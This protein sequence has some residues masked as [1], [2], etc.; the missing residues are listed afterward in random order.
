MRFKGIGGIT[1]GMGEGVFLA[2]GADDSGRSLVGQIHVHPSL[3]S[4]LPIEGHYHMSG[5]KL[6]L[7]RQHPHLNGWNRFTGSMHR[8]MTQ[9]LDAVST[10]HF[11]ACKVS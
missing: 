11:E 10:F 6:R 9:N 3:T 4:N 5:I 8:K 1:A 2:A 7:Q